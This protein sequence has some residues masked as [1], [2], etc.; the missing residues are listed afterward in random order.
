[1]LIFNNLCGTSF[2][3]NTLNSISSK[4]VKNSTIVESKIHFPFLKKLDIFSNSHYDL[5]TREHEWYSYREKGDIFPKSPKETTKFLNKYPCYYL[6]DTSSKNLYL[7]FDEG[8]ENGYTGNILDILKKHNIKAA[9]FVVKPY[10][11]SNP[12]L[13]KRMANEGHLVC[14]HS[15]HHHSMA[16]FKNQ[17]D[18][19]KELSE[20]EKSFEEV[21]GK[22]MPKYFRPPMGKYSELSLAYTKDYNYKTI[23]WSLAYDDWRT[24]HQPSA[25]DAKEKIFSRVHNGSIILLHAVSKTNIQ[26]LDSVLSALEKEGYTFKSLDDLPK[27]P[28]FLGN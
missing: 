5:D 20:V 13:I 14:N 18:F 8:Y 1:M 26:I 7:T 21:T 16:S 4:N 19:N 22:K 17:E 25:G 2:A 12:D 27:E 28:T 23:F 24:N 3:N 10:I 6:G 9:F 11:T 15:S